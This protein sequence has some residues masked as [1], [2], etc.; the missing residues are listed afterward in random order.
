MTPIHKGGST[1]LSNY[2]PISVLPAVSKILERAFMAQLS[3]YLDD[4]NLL[5][6]HQSGF[7]PGYSTS[8]VILYVSDLWKKA[9]DNGLVTFTVFLDLSKAFDCVDHSILLAKLPYY[10]VCGSS[11]RG[12]PTTCRVDNSGCAYTTKPPTGV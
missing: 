8:D 1:E 9:M 11:L 6:P 10:G 3:I 2:R 7:R 12:Y 4:N 5:S